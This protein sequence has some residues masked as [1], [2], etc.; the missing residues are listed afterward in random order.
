MHDYIGQERRRDEIA[1]LRAHVDARLNEQDAKLEEL[2]AILRASK[3]VMLAIKWCAYIATA[4][5]GV[6]TA[7]KSGGAK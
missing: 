1:D 7:W 4:A 5:L 6:W 2:L 3:F